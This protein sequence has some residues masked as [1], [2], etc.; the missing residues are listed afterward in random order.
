VNTLAAS[1]EGEAAG[2]QNRLTLD[3]VMLYEDLGAGLRGKGLLDCAARLFPG[4]PHFNLAIWR[5][6]V[7]RAA[8]VRELALHTAAV[9]DI[10]MLSANGHRALPKVVKLWLRQWLGQKSDEPCALMVS[11]NED[12][13]ASASAAQIISSLEASAKAK[14]VAVFP[15]FGKTRSSEGGPAAQTIQ[16]HANV[17]LARLDDH[18]HWPE[19]QSHWGINE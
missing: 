7:L 2:G 6:D 1:D 15:H 19:L 17:P 13:R 14:D 5:F 3:A 8:I 11:L 16:R 4:T 9:A 10:V 18:W 12:L